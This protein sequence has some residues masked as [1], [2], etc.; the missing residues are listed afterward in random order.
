MTKLVR[1]RKPKKPKPETI[2]TIDA[3]CLKLWSQCIIARDRKCRVTGSGRGLSAHHIR[4]RGHASTR[5]DLE[6]GMCLSWND[7]HFL[8]KMS[9]E[10]FQDGIIDVIG[11]EKYEELKAKSRIPLKRNIQDYRDERE[12]LTRELKGLQ[13]D[14]GKL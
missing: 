1:P 8:Q 4:G 6:N 13:S 14:W 2:S 11:V 12:R 3:A 9:P 10:R 7:W 5:F